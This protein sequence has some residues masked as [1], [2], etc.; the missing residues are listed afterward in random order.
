MSTASV[1]ALTLTPADVAD[2]VDALRPYHAIY[3]SFFPRSESRAWAERYLHGLLSPLPRKS[4]EPIVIAQLGADEKAVRGMQQFLTDSTWD[5]AA[6]LRRHWQE[7]AVDLDDEEGMLIADGSDFAKKG[8]HSVGVQHQYC[9][10]LGKIATCLTGG[11]LT[12]ASPDG[13]TLL[14][15]RLYLPEAWL[16][17]LAFAERWAKCRIPQDVTFQTKNELTREMLR[18]VVESGALHC[19]WFLA[20]EA[21]GRDTTL[22][23]AVDGLGLWYMVEVPLDTHIWLADA[24]GTTRPKALE[25]ISIYCIERLDHGLPGGGDAETEIVERTANFHQHIAHAV[26]EQA[27]RVFEDTTALD[28]A[29]DVLDGHAP[30]GKHLILSLLVV[31]EFAATRLPGRCSHRHPRQGKGQE[32]QVL[33]QLTALRKRI[34]RVIGKPFVVAAA[35]SARAEEENGQRRIDQQH[36]FQRVAPFLA[37]IAAFLFCRIFGAWDGSFG[38]VMA[39]RGG[40]AAPAG[41]LS[42]GRAC[43]GSAAASV[44]ATATVARDTP[45]RCARSSRFRLGASPMVT[46]VAW[47]TGN[48]VWIH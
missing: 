9:G 28:T 21:F 32:P 6:I 37:A 34:G 44:R 41:W 30:T 4:V 17:D 38:A 24:P 8:Q 16:S 23:D 13:A 45:S 18:A 25:F 46:K 36:V 35:A 42:V 33:Q 12:Y 11:F 7:V 29:V 14:D 43:S 47:S 40:G 31:G 10:E 3:G 1:P 20:D 5:D 48:K 2:L 26:F 22:L 39:K 15:R 27:T 19:R